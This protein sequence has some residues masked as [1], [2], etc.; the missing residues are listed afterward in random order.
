MP[1]SS[2]GDGGGSDDDDGDDDD[3]CFFIGCLS[4]QA[5]SR[6]S[7]YPISNFWYTLMRK[8]LSHFTYVDIQI[9]KAEVACPRTEPKWNC[10]RS[11]WVSLFTA[12]G[13]QANAHLLRNHGILT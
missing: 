10:V 8:V 5:G 1:L 13:S 11:Q 4:A 7:T 3:G 2:S 6:F 9:Q 12:L